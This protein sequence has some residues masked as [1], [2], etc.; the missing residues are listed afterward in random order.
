MVK[1]LDFDWSKSFSVTTGQGGLI[2]APMTTHNLCAFDCKAVAHEHTFVWSCVARTHD[3]TKCVVMRVSGD[4]C[5]NHRADG[6]PATV[7]LSNDQPTP[8][9][10]FN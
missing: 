10:T 6:C 9:I 1:D 7:L 3:H 5:G 2:F 8:Y 4:C